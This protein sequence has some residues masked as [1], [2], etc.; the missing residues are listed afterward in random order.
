MGFSNEQGITPDVSPIPI[1]ID[2]SCGNK[3]PASLQ[4]IIKPYSRPPIYLSEA[5]LYP[6]CCCSNCKVTPISKVIP[7]NNEP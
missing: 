7:I 1:T 6:L 2:C 3:V 4:K 5:V